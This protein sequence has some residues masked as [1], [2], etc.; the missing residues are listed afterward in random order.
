MAERTHQAM[1]AQIAREFDS[2]Y[3]YLQFAAWLAARKL[4]GFTHW[5]QVQAREE[6]GHAMKFFQH[7][8]DRDWAIR[9]GRLGAPAAE[10]ATVLEVAQA[11]LDHERYVTRL[12]DDLMQVAVQE[13][14]E[15]A[16]ALLDWFVKEQQE[17]LESSG[18]LVAAVEAAGSDP[19]AL[20]RLDAELGRRG[21]EI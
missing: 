3:L 1:N 17:E 6:R 8:I 18:N 10:F 5:M 21:G 4:P 19:A 14:D 2:E 20:A 12:I 16:R 15:Q 7:L 11:V 9:L 13:R